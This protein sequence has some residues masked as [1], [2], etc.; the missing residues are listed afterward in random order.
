MAPRGWA[1]E[2]R[3]LG[4][5]RPLLERREGLGAG[6]AGAAGG[7]EDRAGGAA[8][9]DHRGFS[10]ARS[11][12]HGHLWRPPPRGHSRLQ[13]G[14]PSPGAGRSALFPSGARHHGLGAE[15]HRRPLRGDAVSIDRS[16]RPAFD[17]PIPVEL[18][19][20][21]R[22]TASPSRICSCGD[23]QR[24]VVRLNGGGGAWGDASS[25]SCRPSGASPSSS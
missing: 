24:S 25:P 18:G 5:H 17:A 14:A 7:D 19:E 22:G 20:A 2:R 11:C 15:V 12:S 13:G 6:A 16:R 23:L 3:K 4:G 1:T 9:H 21:V 8:D 10:A